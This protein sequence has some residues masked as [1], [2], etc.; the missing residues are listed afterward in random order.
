MVFCDLLCAFA[1]AGWFEC[2]HGIPSKLVQ[3]AITE[4]V[5]DFNNHSRK[6]RSATGANSR[7]EEHTKSHEVE[8][9]LITSFL[10][11]FAMQ[12]R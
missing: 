5:D 11:G 7:Y 9:M 12:R 6:I 4:I 10:F 1:D 2:R 8:H 3:D